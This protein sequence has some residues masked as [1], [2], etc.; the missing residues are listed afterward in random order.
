MWSMRQANQPSLRSTRNK[1]PGSAFFL[2]VPGYCF[3]FFAEAICCSCHSP[4]NSCPYPAPLSVTMWGWHRKGRRIF[5]PQNH[6]L[7]YIYK[8]PLPCKIT[9]PMFHR[10]RQV[11]PVCLHIKLTL[12]RRHQN[13]MSQLE[14]RKIYSHGLFIKDHKRPKI[15]PPQV[16]F[17]KNS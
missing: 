8:P 4:N 17:F 12:P 5:P 13:S 2:G 1:L 11:F 7:N 16:L 9:Q 15:C 3:P 6:S 10:L 14:S